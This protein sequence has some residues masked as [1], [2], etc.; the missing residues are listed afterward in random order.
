MY[1]SEGVYLV[2]TDRVREGYS[3]FLRRQREGSGLFSKNM[4]REFKY[5]IVL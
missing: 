2:H 1:Y 5:F 3:L 4:L